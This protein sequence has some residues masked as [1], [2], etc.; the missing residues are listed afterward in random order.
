MY[1]CMS[2][3]LQLTY[4]TVA[5]KNIFSQ[6]YTQ[7]LNGSLC[8][9]F[10]YTAFLCLTRHL[11]WFQNFQV[12]N[13]ICSPLLEL[14]MP[15]AFPGE[16]Y[17]YRIVII[18]LSRCLLQKNGQAGGGKFN[19]EEIVIF[20]TCQDLMTE[21]K[22]EKREEA[23]DQRGAKC[24]DLFFFPFFPFWMVFRYLFNELLYSISLG[25]HKKDFDLCIKTVLWWR[26]SYAHPSYFKV[27]KK[28]QNFDPM[29]Q[30]WDICDIK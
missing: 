24:G 9:A 14:C 13:V 1:T 15:I 4:N 19:K 5:K 10:F 27:F 26:L 18:F 2:R 3:M 23:W 30:P 16:K 20:K 21:E 22:N 28:Q 17:F 12:I 7:A 11:L 29:K 8:P 25:N 6:E